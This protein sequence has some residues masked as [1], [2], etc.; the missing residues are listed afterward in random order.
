[1]TGLPFGTV[2]AMWL[3]GFCTHN[4]GWESSFY[5]FGQTARLCNK[6]DL[7]SDLSGSLYSVAVLS[8]FASYYSISMVCIFNNLHLASWCKILR[9]T[10]FWF[11]TKTC[12]VLEKSQKFIRSE[13]LS[14]L[15][16][17]YYCAKMHNV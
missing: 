10:E 16:K 7:K 12:T 6:L 9:M 1:L 13:N 2:I 17:K 14:N 5:I 3:T 4:L 11:R 15:A 8:L